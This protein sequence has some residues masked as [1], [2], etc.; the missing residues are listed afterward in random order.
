[1]LVR[2]EQH[3]LG[4]RVHVGRWRVHHAHTGA[5]LILLGIRLI[6]TDRRDFPW[7]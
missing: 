4:L 3:E 5:T 2:L 1:M 7:R 6:W